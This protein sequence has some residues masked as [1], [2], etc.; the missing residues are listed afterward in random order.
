MRDKQ[1]C[2][3]K[4]WV[5]L[6]EKSCTESRWVLLRDKRVAWSG[7]GFYGEI[8]QVVLGGDRFYGGIR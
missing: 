6:R 8:S 3:E 5:L 7:D 1:S 2:I 4:R